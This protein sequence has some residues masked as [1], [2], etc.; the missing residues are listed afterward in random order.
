[1]NRPPADRINHEI[2]LDK[3]CAVAGNHDK[4]FKWCSIGEGTVETVC[5]GISGSSGECTA[6]ANFTSKP[7]FA[8]T[9]RSSDSSYPSLS[10]AETFSS[11]YQNTTSQPATTPASIH[12]ETKPIYLNFDQICENG[13][14]PE[15]NTNLTLSEFLSPDEYNKIRKFCYQEVYGIPYSMPLWLILLIIFSVILAVSIATALFWTYW[16]KKRFYRSPPNHLTSRIESH[17]TLSPASTISDADARLPR[18]TSPSTSHRSNQHPKPSATSNASRS[19]G[20]MR[21]LAS[22]NV[23]R[24]QNSRAS[25]ASVKTIN[26]KATSQPS[27]PVLGVKTVHLH[28]NNKG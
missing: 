16:V 21:S 19:Q 15:K 28:S 5:E 8:V 14:S 9:G 22:S 23:S 12:D 7:L 3:K 11:S 20:S 27:R 24:S 10:R 17:W 13:S 2:I 1:M 6:T 4:F 26:T 25:A 18:E